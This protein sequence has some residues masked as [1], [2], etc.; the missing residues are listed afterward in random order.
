MSKDERSLIDGFVAEL[1]A[2]ISAMLGA[3]IT[4]KA[5]NG[6]GKAAKAADPWVVRVNASG[7]SSKVLAVAFSRAAAGKLSAR[8]MMMDSD[9]ADAE[10]AD[11]L[12]ELVQQ[13]IGALSLKPIAKGIEFTMQPDVESA[14]SPLAGGTGFDL[15]VDGD[16]NVQIACV[17]EEGE[18]SD[19]DAAAA[20]EPAP[21]ARAVPKDV[22]ENL[23]VILD[24]DLPLSVRFGHAE[25]TLDALTKLGP[26]SL[27]ELARLPDDPVEL[28]VN[29]KLVARGEVVVVGGNYGVRVHEVVSA[30]ARI[31]TLE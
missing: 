15:P 10:I 2:V 18:A 17:M 20:Y 19:E 13:A 12:K 5:T 6:K 16:L 8:V 1:A 25:L 26:G 29:G 28:L 27:I 30:E 9:P 4:P 14:S 11:T 7:A 31:R 22:P 24:I 3:S 23:D 21:A